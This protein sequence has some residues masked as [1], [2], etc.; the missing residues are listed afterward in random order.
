MSETSILFIIGGVGGFA[1]TL[2][3]FYIQSLKADLAA[4][5]EAIKGLH[6][7]SERDGK[8]LTWLMGKSGYGPP[9][10]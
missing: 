4:K 5:H 3:W 2:F 9:G 10:Y 6:V 7:K 8:L 1:S